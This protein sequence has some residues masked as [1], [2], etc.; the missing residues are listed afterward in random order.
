[1][2]PPKQSHNA[3]D[4]HLQP[5]LPPNLKVANRPFPSSPGPL[6]QNEVKC[7]AFDMKMIFHS[8][9]N[10]THFHK[11][12]SAPGLILKVRVFGT[13]KWPIGL[14]ILLGVL[15]PNK[16]LIIELRERQSQI[17]QFHFK[18]WRTYII[19]KIKY[20]SYHLNTYFPLRFLVI[21]LQESSPTFEKVSQLK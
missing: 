15:T 13:R 2:R 16:G 11:K 20:I 12:G 18:Q 7:S 5:G 4:I 1:M 9:A 3:L 17:L 6:Y 14:D 21:Q 19:S 8:H 10:K